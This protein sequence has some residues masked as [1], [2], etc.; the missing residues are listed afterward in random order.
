MLMKFVTSILLALILSLPSFG[1]ET[2][3]NADF[4]LAV[5]LYNDKLYDLAVEQFRQFV[6]AYP[7]TSQGIEA[8]FYLGL[9]QR[10][11][12]KYEDARFTFQNFALA[13]PDHPKAAEAW[14]NVAEAYDSLQNPKEA[15]LAFERV[16]TF[17]SKS[18]L[19]PRALLKAS[20][21]FEEAG[22]RESSKKTLRALTE[23]YGSSAVV[24]E[25]RLRLAR[26]YF[27]EQQFELAR[28]EAA[29]VADGTTDPALAPAGLQLSAS[30]LA[31]LGR[32]EDA[33]KALEIIVTKYR[34]GPAYFDAL[35]ALAE[36][37]AGSGSFDEAG[38]IWKQIIEGKERPPVQVRESAFLA[39]GDAE[40]M[41]G[42]LKE[43]L[44]SFESAVALRSSRSGEAAFKA[45]RAAERLGNTAKA[46]EWYLRA[47][48]DTAGT[49]DRRAMLAGAVHGAK[50][51][52]NYNLM[53][54]HAL[55][56]REQ[57]PRDVNTPVILLETANILLSE[58]KDP[59]RAQDLYE[60]VGTD[61]PESELVDDAA[62]GLAK[63]LKEGGQFDEALRSLEYLPKRF[64][65]SEF[66]DDA[67]EL[68]FEIRTYEQKDKEGGV[69]NMALLTGDVIAGK[70]KGE[71]AF[72]LAEIYF[73]DL[74]NYESAAEQYAVALRDQLPAE[75]RA[76]AWYRRAQALEFQAW[77]EAREG[78]PA[79][80]ATKAI[81]AYDSLLRSA[82]EFPFREEALS[83]RLRLKIQGARNV[84]E[85]RKISEEMRSE[86]W[87]AKGREQALLAIGEAY[88]AKMSN[89]DAVQVL[90]DLLRMK[91][92]PAV[93]G[94]ALFLLARS[95]F[96]RGERDSA[97]AV[98]N[99][100]LR[101]YPT[102]EFSAQASLMKGRYEV[103]KGSTDAA[104]QILNT[105]EKEYSYTK[106]AV[107]IDLLK[108]DAYY[109]SGDAANA[110]KWYLQHSDRLK[111]SVFPLRDPSPKLIAKLAECSQRRGNRTE[112]KRYYAQLLA[113]DTSAAGRSEVYYMLASLAREENDLET[114]ARYLD[115]SRAG[116][117]S[118]EQRQKT[119]LEELELL[120]RSEDYRTALL[121]I[122][123]L[124][125]QVKN[126]S[127]KQ[128]LQSKEIV[129]YFRI[130]NLAEADKRSNAFVRANPRSLDKAAEFD[131]ER[132]RYHLRKEET[133]LAIRRLENVRSRY[134]R[135]PI[136]PETIY[137]LARAFEMK[138]DAQRSIQL[139]DSLLAKFPSH[140]IAPRGRLSLGNVYY[141]LEQW[142]AASRQY[143]A[144]V[145]NDQAPEL[146]QFAM[147]NLIMA[148]KEIGLF[149]AA[150]Q[151]TRQYI[152]RYPNDP[153][154]ITKRIDIGV[155]YQKL[156]YY[157]QSIVHLESMLQEA[158]PEIEGELRYYIGEAHYYKGSYQ[159]AI[160]EFLKVPY[161][162]TQRTKI[163][164]VSTSYYMAGQSYEKMSKFDE[165][166]TMYKQIIARPG[167]DP[168]FKTAAQKEIDR[169]NSLVKRK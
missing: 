13:F 68:E 144:I 154:L 31:R 142:D 167:I 140:P 158:N 55:R 108:A 113:A 81:G 80:S 82:P 38:K 116:S 69:Q 152:D 99:T 27:S 24:F 21:Y 146:V 109:A 148:Y 128:Y 34:S 126:D 10:Q 40:V 25:A 83:A 35:L 160:L 36:L 71:L 133:D 169:V 112:A 49:I 43:A 11:L 165:A 72:R 162:I 17:H 164:W 161:L 100:F 145:D 62:F 95:R 139:Y 118:P 39:R 147:S 117:T 2:K 106:A 137:W 168:T 130:D 5:S 16:K 111:Q 157:D 47:A 45:A 46:G 14:W 163:D 60:Q 151:L 74:K 8:R 92:S 141:N 123:E 86:Q 105:L 51:V 129:C 107:D 85:V 94:R 29:K 70:P 77:R 26:I 33:K 121:R 61:F 166:I 98:L 22:D 156:G 30:A 155:I 52:G 18:P 15:A 63:A 101:K 136:I 44:A 124:L 138:G 41:Q 143:K 53:T 65:S 131:Y 97:A 23:E 110:L 153:D 134:P 75:L 48:E 120:L 67:R 37:H 84:A 159:Q 64:P 20:T 122:N 79:A 19:A 115:A 127:L 91:P 32:P 103:E 88:Q 104:L 149:D 42:K 59:R 9:T 135:A 90:N 96:E 89:S 56:F 4:K 93:E 73:N 54:R 50:L 150:L 102:H 1:Q 87:S 57:Y 76:M 119:S 114:A 3:E 66:L 78:K 58:L 6:A 12:K 7:N 28:I 125:P 132:G